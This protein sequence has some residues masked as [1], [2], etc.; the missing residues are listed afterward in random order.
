MCVSE[1]LCVCAHVCIRI[2]EGDSAEHVVCVVLPPFQMIESSISSLTPPFFLLVS[3]GKTLGL[4]SR[5]ECA[6]CGWQ[7]E[8]RAGDERP[9]F[10]LHN[11]YLRIL[12]PELY[13]PFSLGL[14]LQTGSGSQGQVK[15]QEP[16]I[17]GQLSL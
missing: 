1:N 12:Q 17:S 6:G 9:G 3:S 10:G 11:P 13:Q 7:P 2:K 4:S 14:G 8:A 5:G 16:W 15:K